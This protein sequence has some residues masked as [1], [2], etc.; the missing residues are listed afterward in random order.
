MLRTVLGGLARDERS[1]GLGV[2]YV[3][4]P[5]P[6]PHPFLLRLLL[7]LPLLALFK[8][9]Y[10]QCRGFAA[11]LVSHFLEETNCEFRVLQVNALP[12]SLHPKL[13]VEK[14]NELI[15]CSTTAVL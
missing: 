15:T 9:V 13:Y 5:P 8:R 6:A 1:N 10:S 12:S 4:A 7:L 14:V 11:G 3:I 2:Q